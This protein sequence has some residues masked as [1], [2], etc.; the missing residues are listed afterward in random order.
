MK[1]LVLSCDNNE[2]LWEPFHHCIEKYWP[3][4]PEVIYSTETKANPYYKTICVNYSLNN[5]SNRIKSTLSVINDNKILIMVDD[6]FIRQ[7]VD[8]DRIDYILPKLKDNIACFNFEKSFDKNDIITDIKDF[9]LRNHGAPYEVSIMC[10]LWDKNKLIDILGDNRTP[11]DVELKPITYNYDFYTN[12]GDYIMYWGYKYGNWAG[13]KR[14]KWC[15]EVVPF[16]EKENIKVDY[17]K[18]GF[19][20]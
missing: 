5:W 20:D 18:R 6:V 12:S 11:W 8:T 13:I 2:D 15:K 4:H 19:C 14:G 3:E 17:T 1:I 10:G 9:K 16:F 7:K